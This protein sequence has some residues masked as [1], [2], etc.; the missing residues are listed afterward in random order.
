MARVVRKVSNKAVKGQKRER[1][2]LLF[3]KKFWIILISIVVVLTAAGITIGVVVANNNSSSK[4]VE[5]DDYFGQTQKY[6]NTDVNFTKMTYEGVKL[7]TNTESELFEEN[8]FVFAASLDSFYPVTL[9]DTNNDDTDLKNDQH[10]KI[11][12]TLI[13]LQYEIDKYNAKAEN[14]DN[15][16]KL[17]IVDASSK[18]G[19]NSASIFSDKEFYSGSSDEFGGPLFAYHTVD[20]LQETLPNG[21]SVYSDTYYGTNTMMTALSNAI[22]YLKQL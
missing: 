20:G 21:K 22:T 4:T 19:N 8:V 11:F 7:H 9:I 14:S 5:V 18:T 10:E 2:G 17:Y 13:Q 3:S 12:N 1:K 15:Q 6:N 16:F